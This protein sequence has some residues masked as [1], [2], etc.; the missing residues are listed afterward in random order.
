MLCVQEGRDAIFVCVCI[1]MQNSQ[2]QWLTP[3][4]LATPEPE[5]WRISET[6]LGSGCH[7]NSME[8]IN[9][10]MEVQL[11]LIINSRPYSKNAQGQKGWGHDSSGRVPA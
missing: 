8:S 11:S 3:V 10:R 5:I 7:L 6:G 9:R 1:R 2:A 4:I